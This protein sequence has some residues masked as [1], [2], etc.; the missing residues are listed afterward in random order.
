MAFIRS[1]KRQGDP[2][3]AMMRAGVLVRPQIGRG[4]R[5]PGLGATHPRGYMRSDMLQGDPFLGKMFKG[6][7]KALKKVTLKGAVKAVGSVAKFAAPILLPGV[8]GAL[9][10]ALLGGGGGGGAAPP[11]AVEAEPAAAA[12]DQ[13]AMFRAML[14]QWIAEQQAA[15][16][17]QQAA[18]FAQW[19][20]AQQFAS[21]S[22]APNAWR[23]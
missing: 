6:I 17:A 15:Q 20:A 22:F 19:Q 9:A 12:M 1:Y 18:A 10:G 5:G 2:L 16:E 11:V 13:Q 7:G 4:R 3:G 8:G 14:E 23:F 21:P